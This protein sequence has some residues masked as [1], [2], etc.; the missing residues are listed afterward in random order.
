I[1]L[2]CIEFV[3]TSVYKLVET[4]FHATPYSIWVFH[5]LALGHSLYESNSDCELIN[6]GKSLP[7]GG[8][9]VYGK[10][11]RYVRIK[12]NAESILAS[13]VVSDIVPFTSEYIQS[14]LDNHS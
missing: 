11:F 1:D 5:D 12:A 3:V 6:K 2:E 10:H 8:V 14:L 13:K 4:S 9:K 7:F